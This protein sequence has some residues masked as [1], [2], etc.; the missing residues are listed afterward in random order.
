[1]KNFD[2]CFKL[3][4]KDEGGY[5]NDPDDRGGATKYGITIAD[6]DKYLKK[7]ATPDDVKNLTVAQ[8]EDIYKHKY[9]DALGCD[10]L[11]AGVDYTCFDYGVNSGLARPRAALKKF[12]DKQGADLINAINDERVTFLNNIVQ[13]RPSQQKFY[14]GWMNRVARVRAVSLN[15]AKTKD[16][17]SGPTTTV[18]TG[19][20]TT[21]GLWHYMS[22]WIHHH[23]YLTAMAVLS[24][25]A[26]VGYLVHY[27]RNK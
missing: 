15:L 11:P 21:Y 17:V 14:K 24:I 7:G 26:A 10:N 6:V 3:L 9:W 25:A 12:S 18:V 19:A 1:M 23:P 13:R 27:M 8:A 22:D 2:Y 4:L 20:A 5:S 16:T